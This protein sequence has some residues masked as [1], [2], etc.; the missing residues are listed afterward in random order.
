[1][2]V[3]P[4]LVVLLGGKPHDPSF[5]VRAA[6]YLV[7]GVDLTAVGDIDEMH[8]ST[9]IGEPGCDFTKRPA[10]KLPRLRLSGPFHN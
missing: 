2:V 1:V 8:A 9:P 6:L 3:T 5:D 7:A 10:A 4:P